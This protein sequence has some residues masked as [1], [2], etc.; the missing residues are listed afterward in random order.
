[1]S[2]CAD[3]REPRRKIAGVRGHCEDAERRRAYVGVVRMLLTL[4]DRERDFGRTDDADRRAV[5]REEVAGA[6]LAV[7]E[8]RAAHTSDIAAEGTERC[9]IG[10]GGLRRSRHGVG[11]EQLA[12]RDTVVRGVEIHQLRHALG[13]AAGEVRHL[14]TRQRM[15]DETC[16]REMKAVEHD[17]NILGQRM[18]VVAGGGLAGRTEAS[19]REGDDMKVR[20]EAGSEIVEDMSGVAKSRKQDHGITGPAEVEVLEAHPRADI[21]E[22]FDG[23]VD[24]S[25]QRSAR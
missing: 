6:K 16:A 13:V 22:S 11:G 18:R 19:A 25:S 14:V 15:A 7:G 9:E 5:R 12:E 2:Q 23:H 17:A 10:R 8:S 1:M 21:D 20:R 24:S 4:E 3:R